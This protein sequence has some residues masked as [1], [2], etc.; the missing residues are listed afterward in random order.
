MM[1]RRALLGS[2][3]SMLNLDAVAQILEACN[4]T[5]LADDSRDSQR[6]L[7]IKEGSDLAQPKKESITTPSRSSSD[8]ISHAST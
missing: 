3:T 7:T 6:S 2:S 1:I 5:P 4:C 8:S